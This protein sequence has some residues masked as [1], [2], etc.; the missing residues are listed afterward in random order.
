MK[1]ITQHSLVAFMENMNGDLFDI[2]TLFASKHSKAEV[3]WL[4]KQVATLD[5]KMSAVENN[6]REAPTPFPYWGNCTQDASHVHKN[7][8]KNL[9]RATTMLSYL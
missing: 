4:N 2:K 9:M 7:G 8:I 1:M 6:L 3:L 5:E